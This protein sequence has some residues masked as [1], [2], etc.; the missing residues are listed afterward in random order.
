MRDVAVL[1]PYVEH[2][3]AYSGLTIGADVPV[4]PFPN[5][6]HH[7]G[8]QFVASRRVSQPGQGTVLHLSHP[9]LRFTLLAIAR[10]LQPNALAV[11]AQ[12]WLWSLL[13]VGKPPPSCLIVPWLLN[14]RAC[15]AGVVAGASTGAGTRAGAG[16]GAEAGATTRTLLL[17]RVSFA[18]CMLVAACC[19]QTA[20]LQLVLLDRVLNHRAGLAGVVAGP[21]AGASAGAR[22]EAGATTGMLVCSIASVSPVVMLVC[23]STGYCASTGGDAECQHVV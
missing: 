21:G 1:P 11:D 17:H 6:L 8:S 23:S 10:R 3:L 2:A 5:S 16:A 9:A 15:L 12:R 19:R 4:L 7:A 13:V 22:A 14:H 20:T 18:S